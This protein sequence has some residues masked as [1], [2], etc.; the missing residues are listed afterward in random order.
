MP[1]TLPSIIFAVILI[2][3][4]ILLYLPNH[5]VSTRTCLRQ[6]G[7]ISV[8]VACIF[9]MWSLYQPAFIIFTLGLTILWWERRNCWEEQFCELKR[10]KKRQ[11]RQLQREH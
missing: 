10:R 11:A 6:A 4:V 1:I 5:I 8:S 2:V 9:G 7:F 3:S